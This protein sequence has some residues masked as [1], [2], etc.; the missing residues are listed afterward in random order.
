MSSQKSSSRS[1]TPSKGVAKRAGGVGFGTDEFRFDILEPNNILLEEGVMDEELWSNLAFSL[2]LPSREGQ[3]CNTETQRL[4]QKM[5][6]RKIMSESQTFEFIKPFIESLVSTCP[7]LSQASRCIYHSDAVPSLDTFKNTV[8]RLPTPKPRISIGYYRDAFSLHHDE[9]QNGIIQGPSGEPCDLNH[10]SQPVLNHYWPFLVVEISDIS[11]I[12]ARQASAISAAT[13]N[14]ALNL[15]AGAAE[16]D[17]RN[18]TS[19]SFKFD[20]KFAKAFS[21]SIHGKFACLSTHSAQ[22]DAP[23][24]ATVVSMYKLDD[25]DEVASLADRLHS[26]MVWAQFNRLGEIVA[27]LD[28]L[29]KKVH[30]NLSGLSLGNTAYDF[31]PSCLKTMKLQPPRRPDRM[32]IALKAGLPRWLKGA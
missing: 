4:A 6:K 11:M 25:D 5:R 32:R 30:G 27:T 16:M 18:W 9:L 15:L 10:V 13:C 8:Y 24:V 12:A 14:N 31:D 17:K 2:G 7:K 26:I 19:D 29:D 28:Q 23:H 21:L 22:G 1:S 20:S 3:R